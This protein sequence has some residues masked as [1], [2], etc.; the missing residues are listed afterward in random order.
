MIAISLNINSFN[1]VFRLD[2]IRSMQLSGS[3]R[4][5]NQLGLTLIDKHFSNILTKNNNSID[6]EIRETMGHEKL[7]QAFRYSGFF[8]EAAINDFFNFN[9]PSWSFIQLLDEKYI[10]SVLLN[11]AHTLGSV[12]LDDYLSL[13]KSK[14]LTFVF[15]AHF[16]H[17]RETDAKTPLPSLEEFKNGMPLILEDAAF[18]TYY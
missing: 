16:P 7:I 6:I 14:P 3:V 4:S 5:I 9:S 1:A 15:S 11:K 8:D 13:I 10:I 18:L 17:F 12:M 2:G